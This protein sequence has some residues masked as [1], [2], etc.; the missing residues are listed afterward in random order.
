MLTNILGKNPLFLLGLSSL[1]NG[2]YFFYGRID[3][4][5]FFWMFQSVLW[6]QLFLIWQ[7]SRAPSEH[8]RLPSLA[9]VYLFSRGLLF[10]TLPI[11]EDDYFRYLWDAQVLDH[12]INPYLFEPQNP[13]LNFLES[14]WR[15]LINY[16]EVKTIYPP[17][18][19]VYFWVVYKFS[20]LN[21]TGLRWGSVFIELAVA[22]ALSRLA[23]PNRRVTVAA[24][25][26]FFPTVMKENINSV[27]YD[28]LAVLPLVWS[29]VLGRFWSVSLA[30]AIC[31]KIF[32]LALV[33][34][35]F[36]RSTR[37]VVFLLGLVLT[38]LLLYLPFL[39]AGTS[40]FSGTGTFAKE[41]RFF[42]SF[43]AVPLPG[44]KWI[45]IAVA[46]I[47]VL[48]LGFT[49]KSLL[50]LVPSV[51][52]LVLMLSPVVNT[53][54]WLWIIPFLALQPPSPI[55]IFPIFTALGYSWF[56]DQRLYEVLHQPTYGV[57]LLGALVLQFITPT[58]LSEL[59]SKL[60][61]KLPSQ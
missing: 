37:K 22:L 39:D 44:I 34:L 16:P 9:L 4:I 33:P 17:L 30:L 5:A 24:V 27:H 58:E 42:E 49:K 28:L 13:F 45:L 48:T 15:N 51:L 47:G 57:F 23:S 55:W 3:P 26:L 60:R 54:Y 38:V 46:S 59:Y 50:V 35:Y 40:V 19:Q 32:P 21:I 25:F 12:G 8:F 41:W 61:Q 36:Y 14:E 29:L 1:L 52:I 7:V 43:A 31:T 18:A 6:V 56:V 53:W 20:G 10:N 2:L 11:Y